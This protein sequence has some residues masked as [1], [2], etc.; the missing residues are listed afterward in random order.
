MAPGP[1]RLW[2]RRRS[3]RGTPPPNPPSPRTASC[4][5]RP[6]SPTAPSSPPPSVPPPCPQHDRTLR[7]KGGPWQWAP[8]KSGSTT[9]AGR[10]WRSCTRT[11]SP[12]ATGSPPSARPATA[13]PSSSPTGSSSTRLPASAQMRGECWPRDR[14]AHLRGFLH[15][16][17]S[18]LN[19]QQLDYAIFVVE[20]V[21]KTSS[22]NLF[23]TGFLN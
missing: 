2:T 1:W 3:G 9:R 5:S 19:K 22:S 10:S 12:G 18:L 6:T 14:D 17:H 13:S 11:W 23:T 4:P 8:S 15:N 20:Q 16:F 7:T 21:N